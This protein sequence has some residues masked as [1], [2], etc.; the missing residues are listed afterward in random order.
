MKNSV[1]KSFIR[2]LRLILCLDFDNY[3]D[4]LSSFVFYQSHSNTLRQVFEKWMKNDPT[5]ASCRYV[6]ASSIQGPHHGAKKSTTQ[7]SPSFL[8]LTISSNNSGVKINTGGFKMS[9]IK[10]YFFNVYFKENRSPECVFTWCLRTR[11]HLEKFLFMF[12]LSTKFSENFPQ[13]LSDI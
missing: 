4:D 8:W 13:F 5:L 2:L 12:F 1:L 3:N 9:Y 11:L 10:K 7:V 6:G